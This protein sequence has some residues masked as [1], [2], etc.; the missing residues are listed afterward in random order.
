MRADLSSRAPGPFTRTNPAKVRT[1]CSY[2]T[3]Y[4]PVAPRIS[5]LEA[6][7]A[8]IILPSSN[9][10]PLAIRM[11]IAALKT[12]IQQHMSDG[13]VT[14]VGSGLSCAEGLPSMGALATH[15][16]LALGTLP[17]GKLR[18]EWAKIAPSLTVVGLEQALLDTPPSAEL[19]DLI[20]REVAAFVSSSEN[21][22][23]SEV[24][25]KGR[26]LRFTRLLKYLLCPPNGI[27][28]VTTNYDRLLE[29]AAEEAGIGVDTMFVGTFAGRLDEREARLS[30]CR[31]VT[32]H[33]NK[34]RFFFA[35][36]MVLSKLHGSLDWYERNG[37]PVRH[38][39]ELAGA[40]RLIIP[41]GQ[42][43][44]RNG[45]DSPFDVHR[46]RANHAIDR[47]SCF[48][49]I[50]YGF[51]DGHLETHLK[52]RMKSGVSTLV[53]THSLSTNAK[54]A[55]SAAPH[56]LALEAADIKGVL[57]TRVFSP[58]AIDVFS[59]VSL[60]DVGNLVKEVFE[61]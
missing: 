56:F 42:N 52:E 51:N 5:L 36:R 61:P 54:S 33:K 53:L 14:I 35:N 6:P 37:S 28:V 44:Y 32:L 25:E 22:L 48:L 24:F 16:S 23:I 19:E 4:H 9:K 27:Q 29:V 45:Y 2:H 21:D 39:G 26:V 10:L 60:W 17:S 38:C 47:A 31:D 57:S 15:L 43:K 40:G 41:P 7:L 1:T 11:D 20:R 50:G 3:S 58:G 49:I 34:P 55:L 30:F 46:E 12:Q 8:R 59:G 13:L 18:D